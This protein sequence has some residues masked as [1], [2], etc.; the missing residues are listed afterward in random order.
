[1]TGDIDDML[2][3]QRFLDAIEASTD[4]GVTERPPVAGVKYKAFEVH[5]LRR[6]GHVLGLAIAHRD[7]EMRI[8]DVT[9]GD[10]SV[11]DAAAICK[12]YGITRITGAE[13]DEAVA[14]ALAVC[15]VIN[16]LGDEVL[17]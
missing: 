4:K 10:L 5:T 17:Q 1:M 12:R 9:R 13:G 2:D 8:V 11:H 14:L 6:P 7:G 3:H 16:E 15:G